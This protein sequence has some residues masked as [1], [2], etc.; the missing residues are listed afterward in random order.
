MQI[1]RDPLVAY[2]DPVMACVRSALRMSVSFAFGGPSGG[3]KAVWT[4][5]ETK[6]EEGGL[7]L[8]H[9]LRELELLGG[10]RMAWHAHAYA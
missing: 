4:P 6:R 2:V 10:H 7:L 9:S 1:P 8:H 5:A 3:K